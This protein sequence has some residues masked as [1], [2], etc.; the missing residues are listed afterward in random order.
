MAGKAGLSMPVLDRLSDLLG[1][2][3]VTRPEAN[4]GR[5]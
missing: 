3:L 1:L 2:D 5:G 4:K